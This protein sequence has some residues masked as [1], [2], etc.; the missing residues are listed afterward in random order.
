VWDVFRGDR[1]YSPVSAEA[2]FGGGS[3]ARPPAESDTSK[4]LEVRENL[5]NPY[6]IDRKKG[7]KK[8]STLHNPYKNVSS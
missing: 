2:I 7:R 8:S 6:N 4:L 1:R 5:Q 3:E